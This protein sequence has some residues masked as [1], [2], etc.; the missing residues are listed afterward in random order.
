MIPAY[1]T[2]DATFA[3]TQEHSAI[4]L[5][6]PH[7]PAPY[8]AATS[9][10]I[11]LGNGTLQNHDSF[12]LP[13][14]AGGFIDNESL[15]PNTQ[16]QSDMP[17]PTNF[18]P[19][20]MPCTTL[21]HHSRPVGTIRGQI[22]EWCRPVAVQHARPTFTP[23]RPMVSRLRM[24]SAV[25]GAAPNTRTGTPPR[26][27]FPMGASNKQ[28]TTQSGI[29]PSAGHISVRSPVTPDVRTEAKNHVTPPWKCDVT[30]DDNDLDFTFNPTSHSTQISQMAR[31]GA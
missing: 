2:F 9:D 16:E 5:P 15:T 25:Q 1:P 28:P 23:V 24:K 26:S 29:S 27:S 4:Q 22:A 8:L 14:Q 3:D 30:L 12:A 18:I 21:P 10:K 13:S 11:H 7:P 19:I 31:K 17:P 6:V 20:R